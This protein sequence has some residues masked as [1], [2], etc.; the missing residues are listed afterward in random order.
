MKVSYLNH[1]LLQ[2]I[3][4]V[5]GMP[6]PISEFNAAIPTFTL[7]RPLVLYFSYYYS[8]MFFFMQLFCFHDE[9]ILANLLV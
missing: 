6:R 4:I 5:Y 9:K 8:K 1:F 7:L 3:N 2:N